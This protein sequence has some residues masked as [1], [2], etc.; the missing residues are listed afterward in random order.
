M[1]WSQLQAI[2]DENRK[3]A[4]DGR[5]PPDT[6]PNDGS[7]LDVRDDGV[8]NCPMGDYTWGGPLIRAGRRRLE[9]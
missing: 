7:L 9:D 1:S 3:A 2:L 4:A 8:R 5:A 6:C